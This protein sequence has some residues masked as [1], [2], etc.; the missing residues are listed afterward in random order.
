MKLNTQ[1]LADIF[2]SNMILPLNKDFKLGGIVNPE[3]KVTVKF[4]QQQ[5]QTISDQNGA[6][7]VKINAVSDP[8][9]VATILVEAGDRKQEIENIRFGKV[10][11]LSVQSNI[12]YRLKDEAHFAQVK[13]ELSEHKYPDLHYYNVPQVDYIDPETGEVKPKE[14]HLEQW[15]QVDAENC[16]YMSAVGFYMIKKMREEGVAGPIAIVDCFKGGTSASV[17]IKKSDLAGD[18]E[19][20]KKFLDEYHNQ[21]AGKTWADFDRETEEYNQIVNKHNQDLA[22]YL[23]MHPDTSLSTAKNIVGHTPWPPPARPDLFTRPCGLYETMMSQVKDCVFN[24][25]VWYQGE[26]D[27]DRAEQYHKLLP[28]LIHTWRRRLHDPSLP[29]KL[30]QLPG[31]ADYPEDS[32]A[33]IRQVQLQTAKAMPE[34]DLVSFVDGGEE[35]NIHP[36]NK[37]IVGERLGQIEVGNDYAGTPF[38]K[39]CQYS[40]SKL[41]LT[42]TRCEQLK[43]NSKT[44]LEVITENRQKQV[45]LTAADLNK[46]QIVMNLDEKPQEISYAYANFT[47]EIGLY[48]E[49]DYPV[50]PFKIRL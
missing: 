46:N 37:K 43:L 4:N 30:I 28:L 15:H 50:S 32:A 29:V 23:K 44:I 47:K 38:V 41:I 22:R 19:L 11:L 42:I 24:G 27:T 25:M 35:H 1:I 17:W 26:N 12:E 49:L 39:K 9:F 13:T 7:Q 14:I 48:N 6:W 20:N 34:V 2:Q 21:I 10:Y 40:D 5:Y 33:L 36:T 3:E 45:E 16:G 31:Y 8:K 18:A